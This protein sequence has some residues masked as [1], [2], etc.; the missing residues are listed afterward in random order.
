MLNYIKKGWDSMKRSKSFKQVYEE[1]LAKLAP[2]PGAK[3]FPVV[4]YKRFDKNFPTLHRNSVRN[5]GFDLF[6]RLKKPIEIKPG[7]VVRIPLNVATEIVPY[8]VALLFQRSSTFEKWG[9][10]LTNG[11]GVIDSLYCGDGDEWKA[12]FQNM[13]NET[14]VINPGD[15]LCQ[16]LFLP[17]LPVVLQ[18]VDKLGNKDRGGFGSTFDNSKD[19]KE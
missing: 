18:E 11:V 12:E 15:K 5:A 4:K 6:A 2:F 16:A 9:L 1:A 10:R 17:L 8:G 19:L 14:V 7:E 13:R 3:V